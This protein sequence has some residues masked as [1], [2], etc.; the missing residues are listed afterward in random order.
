MLSACE[1][2]AWLLLPLDFD[3]HP[4]ASSHIYLYSFDITCAYIFIQALF[5]AHP[6]LGANVYLFSDSLSHALTNA[7]RCQEYSQGLT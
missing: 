2:C 3:M 6:F 5:C 1:G 7:T 4:L